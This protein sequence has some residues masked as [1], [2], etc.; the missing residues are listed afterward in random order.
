MLTDKRY[1]CKLTISDFASRYLLSCEAW[2][3]T[4]EGYA[5]TVFA[6]VFKKLGLPKGRFSKHYAT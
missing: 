4:P 2:S 5:F 1:C 3:T 6:R